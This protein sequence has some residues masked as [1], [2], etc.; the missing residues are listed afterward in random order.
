MTKRINPNAFI[1]LVRDLNRGTTG[2]E[3]SE[4][5]SELQQRCKET[6][7]AGELTLK[8]K[9]KPERGADG[10]FQ[11]TDDIKCK[12][13]DFDRPST[14]MYEH[15]DMQ[16]RREDP[17]QIKMELREIQEPAPLEVREAHEKST[18]LREVK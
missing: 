6:G 13:P 1:E 10:M 17:K 16:L 4:Q 9:I 2:E 18:K 14:I 11:V 8:I 15:G 7:K 3:L 12:L 5:L